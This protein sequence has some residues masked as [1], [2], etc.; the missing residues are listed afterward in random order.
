MKDIQVVHL[1]SLGFTQEKYGI[2]CSGFSSRH[3]FSSAKQLKNE[4][5]KLGLED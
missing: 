1:E 5:N 3:L 4:V 2:V